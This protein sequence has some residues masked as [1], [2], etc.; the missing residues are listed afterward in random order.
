MDRGELTDARCYAGISQHRRA[1]QAGRDFSGNFQPFRAQAIFEKS[2]ARSVAARP[3]QASKEPGTDRI[4]DIGKHDRD[5]AA[6]RDAWAGGCQNDVGGERH[7][8]VGILALAAIIGCRPAGDELDI[9]TVDPAQILQSAQ[10]C[11]EPRLTF[12]ITGGKLS[13]TPMRRTAWARLR[14]HRERPCRCC[15]NNSSNEIAPSYCPPRL[16]TNATVRLQ[17]GFAIG[18]MGFRGTFCAAAI[19]RIQSVALGHF[20]PFR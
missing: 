11:P 7:Q 15:A 5:G 18:G 16:R 14:A 9:A 12:W 17:Q 19:E 8:F 4:D 20:R 1:R 10:E 3:R 13:S 2:E 6:R